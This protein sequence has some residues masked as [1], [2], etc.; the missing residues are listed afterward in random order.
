M[1]QE[2]ESLWDGHLRCGNVSKHQIDLFSKEVRL[3]HSAPY[4]TGPTARQSTAAEMNQMIAKKLS[5]G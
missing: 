1:L 4:Q 5:N 2:F 3:I